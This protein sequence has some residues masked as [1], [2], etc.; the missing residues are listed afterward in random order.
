MTDARRKL[1]AYR[2]K[3]RANSCMLDGVIKWTGSRRRQKI[4]A[5]IK[6]SFV[7]SLR[8]MMMLL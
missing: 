5:H 7:K 4:A 2:T 8:E 6:D 3:L 1:R